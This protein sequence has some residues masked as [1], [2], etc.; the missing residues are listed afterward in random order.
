M[1]RSLACR[2]GALHGPCV[3]VRQGGRTAG[4][5]HR[6]PAR[7][8]GARRRGRARARTAGATS[9][10]H[11]AIQRLLGSL[12]RGSGGERGGRRRTHTLCPRLRRRPRDLRSAPLPVEAVLSHPPKVL[13]AD[14][15]L[16]ARADLRGRL[17]EC[18]PE[19]SFWAM[20]GR[21][22]VLVPKKIKGRVN[23]RDL[24][25]AWRCSPPPAF[26]RRAS[27]RLARVRCGWGSTIWWMPVPPPG[28]RGV[29]ET[30][31][32]CA[33]PT[34]RAGCLWP[35]RRDPCVRPQIRRSG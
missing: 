11:A 22:E 33:I 10:R 32:R 27:R 18:H 1:G 5:R 12:P 7:P 26:P 31:R 6:H 21:R 9:S 14:R 29:S 34:R 23:P 35:C 24:R 17:F 8:A 13:E 30:A 4:R 28:P 20:N 16:R 3:A 25:R 15:L 19:V 2:R